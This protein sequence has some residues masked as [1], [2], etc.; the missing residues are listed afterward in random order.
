MS[1]T[2]VFFLVLTVV[3]VAWWVG[4]RF[5]DT[6]PVLITWVVAGAI[7]AGG[8]ISFVFGTVERG[9]GGEGGWGQRY[10]EIGEGKL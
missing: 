5:D 6:G 9:T 3:P 8:L 10:R 2:A 1:L 7:I 4:R